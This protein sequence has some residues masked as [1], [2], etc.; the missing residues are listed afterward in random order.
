METTSTTPDLI[1]ELIDA[2]SVGTIRRTATAERGLHCPAR[3][4][5]SRNA[6]EY[7]FTC[8]NGTWRLSHE[9]IY[10][11]CRGVRGPGCDAS[12]FVITDPDLH[13]ALDSFLPGSKGVVR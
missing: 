10:G 9:N 11:N 12:G 1:A 4:R 3:V 8:R 6:T 5:I 13:D 7:T 2:A